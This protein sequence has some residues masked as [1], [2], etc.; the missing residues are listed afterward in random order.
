[1]M[2]KT[3]NAN[4]EIPQTLENFAFNLKVRGLSPLH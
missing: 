3:C 2:S 1:M 4:R